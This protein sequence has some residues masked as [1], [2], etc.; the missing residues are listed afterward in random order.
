MFSQLFRPS[1]KFFK[2]APGY[3]LVYNRLYSTNDSSTNVVQ[4][5]S[6]RLVF[7]DEAT[8]SNENLKINDAVITGENLVLKG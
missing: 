5:G 7:N 4:K 3:I 8:V 6:E 2:Q 1:R